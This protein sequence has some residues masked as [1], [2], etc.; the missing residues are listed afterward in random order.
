[1]T[2]NFSVLNL[3][4]EELSDKYKFDLRNTPINEVKD[5]ISKKDWIVLHDA[6]KYGRDNRKMN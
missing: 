4:M 2:Y 3:L 6:V 1:M 5:K